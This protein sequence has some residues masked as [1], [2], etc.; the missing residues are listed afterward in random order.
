M[1]RCQD[2]S[3][4]SYSKHAP[5]KY[6]YTNQGPFMNKSLSKAIMTRTKMKNRNLKEKIVNS[7][8]DYKIVNSYNDYK[9]VNSYNDY[10]IVN[11][12]NDYKIV[13]SYNDY[14]T[15]RNLC[16]SLFRKAK[17]GGNLNPSIVTDNKTL[18]RS[19]KPIFSEKYLSNEKITLIDKSSIVADD[20][21]ITCYNFY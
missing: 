16:T 15:Q 14:K 19:V 4:T 11:S 13:N 9:I 20:A 18:W 7:Y 12:Y 1:I 6:K 3:N 17:K 10:K 5:L 8:N 21:L 2:I